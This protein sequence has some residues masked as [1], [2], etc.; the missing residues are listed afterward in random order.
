MAIAK[1]AAILRISTIEESDM[2]EPPSPYGWQIWHSLASRLASGPADLMAEIID[3]A[4][5]D[6]IHCAFW[7]N[8]SPW[9]VP[10]RRVFDDF[11][12]FVRSGR[13][14]V[15]LDG[16]RRIL[17]PG[18]C[19][20]L[21]E[22]RSHAFGLAPGD[23]RVSH[24]II[25]CHA[26]RLDGGGLL[27][28]LDS[29]FQRLPGAWRAEMEKILDCVALFER[30]ARG[31]RAYARQLLSGLLL[32][33]AKEG[34]LKAGPAKRID[35]RIQAA[36]LFIDANAA[37]NIGVED[38]AAS[39]GLKQVQFRS[40]FKSQVGHG[41]AKELLARRLRSAC[42]LL[43]FSTLSIGRV[44]IEAGFGSEEYFCDVFKRSLGCRPGDYRERTRRQAE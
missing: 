16:A 33:L 14:L 26:R 17:K 21:P 24:A 19:L 8:R 5:F 9:F 15:E 37:L 38:I 39:C 23:R 4:Q 10:S 30:N 27:E 32:E 29:P 43:S 12:V 28:L 40:L 6:V 25:H 1:N 44:A 22:G 35:A 7:R 42:R 13:L 34:R 2:Q 3:G 36:L 11:C 18:E 20:L 31:G 41:P